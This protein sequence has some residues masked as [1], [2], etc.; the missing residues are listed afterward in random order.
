MFRAV[1][2]PLSSVGIFEMRVRIIGGKNTYRR[3]DNKCFLFRRTY[4]NV[5][6]G[7]FFSLNKYSFKDIFRSSR[8]GHS[9]YEPSKKRTTR[10]YKKTT[11]YTDRI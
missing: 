1:G 2:E 10:E 6:N 11:R 3:I 8:F 7:L 4:Y 5:R 9:M